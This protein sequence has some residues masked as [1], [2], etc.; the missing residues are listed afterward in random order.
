[1]FKLNY[2]LLRIK[3]SDITWTSKFY[4]CRRIAYF[5]TTSCLLNYSRIWIKIAFGFITTAL[6]IIRNKQRGYFLV[7]QNVIRIK[8]KIIRIFTTVLFYHSVN[9]YVQFFRSYDFLYN[10]SSLLVRAVC[11]KSVHMNCISLPHLQWF[12]SIFEGILSLLLRT[13][14][15]LIVRTKI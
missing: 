1:M 9:V 8:F 7:I 2:G 13:T 3:L 6:F 12:L 15:S 14:L 10:S 11:V 5:Y 4:S